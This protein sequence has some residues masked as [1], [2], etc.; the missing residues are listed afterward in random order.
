MWRK[1]LRART[2]ER[3]LLLTSIE[4][5]LSLQHSFNEDIV[6]VLLGQ[7]EEEQVT[8]SAKELY[9]E[10][11]LSPHLLVVEDAPLNAFS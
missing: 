1:A 10:V 9:I 2:G 8:S 6:G 5:F 4:L 3:E 7:T 11:L